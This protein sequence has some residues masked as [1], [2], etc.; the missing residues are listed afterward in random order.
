M[1]RCYAEKSKDGMIDHLIIQDET[2]VYI[3]DPGRKMEFFE[4]NSLYQ[5]SIKLPRKD[6]QKVMTNTWEFLEFVRLCERNS[7]M[8]TIPPEIRAYE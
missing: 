5:T 6:V 7:Y 3:Y 8:T 4:R 1:I 2:G